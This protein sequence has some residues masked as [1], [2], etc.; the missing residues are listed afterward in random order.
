MN[1]PVFRVFPKNL[2]NKGEV[3]SR[4]QRIIQF[5]LLELLAVGIF[6]VPV[7]LIHNTIAI[8]V[9]EKLQSPLRNYATYLEGV[10]N[11]ALFLL[12]YKI[13]CRLIERRLSFEISWKGSILETAT[14]FSAGIILIAISTG[15][16]AIL[17]FYKVSGFNSNGSVL[18]DAFFR[19]GTGAFVQEFFIRLILFRLIEELIGTWSSLAVI[20]C[21]FGLI[22]IGNEN[23][24]ILTSL[25]IAISDILFIAAFVYTRRLWLVWGL[26]F[27]WNFMQDGVLGMPNSG[28]T[29][30]PSWIQ[31]S[32]NGPTW[33][34]GGAFGIEAS[35][36]AI[37]LQV[38]LGI[39]LLIY[40]K[41]LGQFI[42][43]Y[44]RRSS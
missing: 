25:A 4:W 41:N 34:T 11:I 26:H 2:L 39:C 15:I 30:L 17:G 12:A 22:H 27:G 9:L 6:V 8:N 5:P 10:V 44:W 18:I 40:A 20:A 38:A 31:P 29:E 36:I 32:I 42:A 1:N 16:I 3:S 14:G 35:V 28:I 37:A 13:Y 7:A 33:L 43:P 19:F 23:A 24:T 21:F